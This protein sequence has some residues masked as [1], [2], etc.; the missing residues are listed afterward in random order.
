MLRFAQ[1]L[2][3]LLMLA[4]FNH[5]AQAKSYR[6]YVVGEPKDARVVIWNIKPK[7]QQGMYLPPGTYDIQV[8]KDG[9]HSKRQKIDLGKRDKRV[10]FKLKR[11]APKTQRLYV[12]VKPAGATIKVMT[13]KPKF[14][15]G[16]ALPVGEHKVVVSHPGYQ[17][18]QEIINIGKEDVRLYMTLPRAPVQTPFRSAN[19]SA[20]SANNAIFQAATMT[21][22]P[23]PTVYITTEPPY[24]NIFIANLNRQYTPGMVLPLGQYELQVSAPGYQSQRQWINVG[25]NDGNHHIACSTVR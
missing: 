5:A 15:Q 1:I 11:I 9:Y 3:L 10:I 18:L 4:L 16:M 7:F 20:K 6:L 25:Y 23:Q 14:K 13:V 17:T 24:A 2:S 22:P 8:S 12:N 21:N 19:Y